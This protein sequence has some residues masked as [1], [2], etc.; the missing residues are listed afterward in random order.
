MKI[1]RTRGF[2]LLELLVSLAV[3]A[4]ITGIAVPSMSEIIRNNR[5]DAIN[6][7][8]FTT[9]VAARS[10]AV[11]R[12]QNVVVCKSPNGIFCATTN[13]W[14]Q[15]WLTYVDVAGDGV[16]D[17]TDP[18]INS[19]SSLDANYTLRTGTAFENRVTI[20]PSGAVSEVGTFRLCG[21]DASL[22]EGKSLILNITGRP[23]YSDG[24]SECP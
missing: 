1:K 10:E 14:E 3:L 17:I 5:I 21:P 9:I 20:L 13:S 22:E 12:N 23:R 16:K 24:V 19:Y 8:L 11:S 6:Q 15:G 18:I 2:S 7:S 4:I